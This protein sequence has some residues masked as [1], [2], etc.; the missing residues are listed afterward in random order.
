M[1]FTLTSFLNLAFGLYVLYTLYCCCIILL[2]AL[3]KTINLCVC[4]VCALTCSSTSSAA[5]SQPL[6]T[7]APPG[8]ISE[9]E[10]RIAPENKDSPYSAKLTSTVIYTSQEGPGIYQDC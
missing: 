2:L 5:T 7:Q 1:L 8:R 4:Y 10:P 9:Y 3:G 6:Q